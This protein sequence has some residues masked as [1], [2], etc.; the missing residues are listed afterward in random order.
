MGYEMFREI[1]HPYELLYF[2]VQFGIFIYIHRFYS[3]FTFNKFHS[4]AIEI[5]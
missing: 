5:V 1:Q 3:H 2:K 4:Y